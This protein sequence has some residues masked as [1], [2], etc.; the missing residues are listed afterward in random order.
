MAVLSTLL[1][2]WLLLL[3]VFKQNRGVTKSLK[4]VGPRI[5]KVTCCFT[6]W[7]MILGVGSIA[8]RAQVIG[9]TSIS[10][11]LVNV[12]RFV[13]GV[14]SLGLAC[15]VIGALIQW[16]WSDWAVTEPI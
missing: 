6:V 7:G 8:L 3:D 14:L 12:G 9:E 10:W 16:L 2:F 5:L 4:H 1:L 13:I 11:Q 15:S